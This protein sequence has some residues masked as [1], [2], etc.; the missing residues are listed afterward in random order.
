[1]NLA[2]EA[3]IT[4]FGISAFINSTLAV[5]GGLVDMSGVTGFKAAS[6]EHTLKH[7]CVTGIWVLSWQPG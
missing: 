4:D 6:S 3:K 5:V 2:G 7:T 1:M